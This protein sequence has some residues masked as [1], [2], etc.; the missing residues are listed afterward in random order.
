MLVYRTGIAR[1]E[2]IIMWICQRT[3]YLKFIPP[4]HTHILIPSEDSE[5]TGL[6]V[7]IADIRHPWSPLGCRPADVTLKETLTALQY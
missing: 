7:N 4:T 3:A 6:K 1:N 2:L 5:P